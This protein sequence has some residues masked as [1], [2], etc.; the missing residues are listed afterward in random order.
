MQVVRVYVSPHCAAAANN[1]NKTKIPEK[2]ALRFCYLCRE[3]QI[4]FKI[5]AGI[6]IL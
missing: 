5:Y 1:K 4:P 6:L 2:H 3:I